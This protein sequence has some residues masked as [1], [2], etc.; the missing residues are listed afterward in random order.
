MRRAS[1]GLMSLLAA[2]PLV[3]APGIDAVRAAEAL[4]VRYQ[5]LERA[6][7]P[8]ITELYSDQAIIYLSAPTATGR[9]QSFEVPA[10]IYTGLLRQTLHQARARGDYNRYRDVKYVPVDAGVRIRGIRHSVWRGYDSP[11]SMLVVR[12]PDGRWVV[13]EEVQK[14]PQPP[15]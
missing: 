1:A 5:A 8:A 9:M 10:E 13:V 3:A 6:F 14:V 11:F 7:D 15:E 2:A 12:R 4:F